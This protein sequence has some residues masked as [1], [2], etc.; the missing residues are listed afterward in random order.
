METSLATNS[1]TILVRFESSVPG[2]PLNE[3]VWD[4]VTGAFWDVTESKQIGY[5]QDYS[6][7][8]P[9]A[10]ASGA[11]GGAI[12]GAIVGISGGPELV[13]TRI[14]IPF[15][16]IFEGVFRSGLQKAFPNSSVSAD[17]LGD[18]G[19][20]QVSGP[21][22]V[23]KMK[24]TEFYV[25]EQPLNH[26]NLKATVQACAFRAGQTDVPEFVYEAHDQI[27]NQPIGTMASTSSGFIKEMNKIS[28]GFAAN[29]SNEILESL[30]KRIDH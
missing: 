30:Q 7:F 26:L 3:T 14:I 28:N 22:Y 4:N 25:W 13:D 9:V 18:I 19:K 12:G 5:T 8:I 27:T 21:R 15:G 16:R 6:K 17:D 1:K 11:V 23:I 24:I 20:S 2:K 29:L 10:I